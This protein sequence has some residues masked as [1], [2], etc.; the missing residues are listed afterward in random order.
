MRFKGMNLSIRDF[1]PKIAKWREED[2]DKLLA[3][4]VNNGW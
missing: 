1:Q 3:G 4:G 2:M